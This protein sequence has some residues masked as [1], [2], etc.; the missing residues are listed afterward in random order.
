MSRFSVVPSE[1]SNPQPRFQ[2]IGERPLLASEVLRDD[3]APVHPGRTAVRIWLAV[4]ALVLAGLGWAFHR[5]AGVPGL[6]TE[7]ALQSFAAAGA[8]SAIALLPFPYGVRALLSLLVATVAMLL[9]LRGA[10][11]LAGLA[12]D[13]GLAR[14]ITRLVAVVALA[15][16]LMFRAR[17]AE[18]TRS[19]AL[20]LGA[21]AIA[22]PFVIAEGALVGDIGVALSLRAWA[23]LN[24]LVVIASLLALLPAAAGIGSDALAALVLVLVPGEIA[25]RAW[26]PLAGPDTG[27]FTY[28]LTA[29]AFTAVCLPAS[30]GLFQ[31]VSAAL[32][33]EARA[34]TGRRPAP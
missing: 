6:S 23:A 18:F 11:P 3:A 15:G 22:V 4:A 12:V 31:L 28:P 29:V 7:S 2:P 33:P 24:A 34:E 27:D 1:P 13:G 20:L 9:G 25:I 32:A 21:F 17:Y 14:D 16:A 8:F 26:T 10:G 19:R 30:L 5:G